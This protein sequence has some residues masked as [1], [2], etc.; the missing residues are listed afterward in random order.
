MEKLLVHEPRRNG[1]VLLLAARVGEAQVREFRLF[2][3]YEFQYVTGC[4]IAS[5]KGVE[6]AAGSKRLVC[7][8]G[9]VVWYCRVRAR[10]S[11]W[12]IKQ[13]ESA[14]RVVCTILVRAA[15]I[16]AP[17]A[18]VWQ[19]RRGSSVAAQCK[20]T[21]LVRAQAP[22]RERRARTAARCAPYTR[23]LFGVG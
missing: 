22:G 11:L 14:W 1:H 12:Q 15:R 21:F 8:A 19:R 20:R 23:A 4:H 13:L 18:R 6:L 10:L 17:F 2:F 9:G 16:I 3:F 7:E 5:G